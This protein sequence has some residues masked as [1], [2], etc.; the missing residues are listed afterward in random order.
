MFLF[1][2]IFTL[3]AKEGFPCG[4]YKDYAVYFQIFYKGF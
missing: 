1:T 3:R 4:K 2:I